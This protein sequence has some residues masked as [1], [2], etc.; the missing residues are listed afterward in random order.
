M[1][2]EREGDKPIGADTDAARDGERDERSVESVRLRVAQTGRVSFLGALQVESHQEHDEP[3]L[4]VA[5][6]Q[7]GEV[8]D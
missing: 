3:K 8:T 6:E 2:K 5:E 1:V 4:D 7:R